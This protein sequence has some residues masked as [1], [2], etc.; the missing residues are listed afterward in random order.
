METPAQ[1]CARLVVALEDL[2]AREAA[3][4][5][6]DDITTLMSLQQQADPLVSHLGRHGPAV[7]DEAL[8]SR[9]GA[10]LA[11]RQET[12]DVLGRRIEETRGR[13][14]ELDAS[15]R[16]VARVVPAYGQGGETSRRLCAVG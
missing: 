6:C 3:S 11:R 2:V 7:V 9:I 10:L 14:A 1:R 13:L 16:R 8:R 4:L 12:A 15:R 5:A